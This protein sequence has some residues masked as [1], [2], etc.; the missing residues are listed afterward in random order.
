MYADLSDA[1]V[2][3]T[4]DAQTWKG[5]YFIASVYQ[6]EITNAGKTMLMQKRANRICRLFWFDYAKTL[7]DEDVQLTKD[8]LDI[9]GNEGMDILYILPD[10]VIYLSQGLG[11]DKSIY[12]ASKIHVNGTSKM[13]T[14]I[15]GVTLMNTPFIFT[16]LTCVKMQKPTIK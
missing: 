7:D 11:L 9:T 3:Y 1:E 10:V 15:N 14:F 6:D 2:S 5:A 12:A 13:E 16:K 4:I 8:F